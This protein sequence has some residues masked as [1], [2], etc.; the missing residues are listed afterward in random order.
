MTERQL[1]QFTNLS[2]LLA[3][4]TNIIIANLVEVSLLVLSLDGLTLAVNNCVLGNNAVLRRVNLHNL[5][6]DLSHTTSYCEQVTLSDWP[7]GLTEIGSEV[8]V[9][10]RAGQALDGISDGEDSNALGLVR[11]KFI[12][13]WIAI[14]YLGLN[15][16]I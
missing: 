1:D 14:H 11:R 9:E 4:S 12:S 10:E 8:D 2:H 7:V 16:H 15:L 3:A 13:S 6:F 5:K